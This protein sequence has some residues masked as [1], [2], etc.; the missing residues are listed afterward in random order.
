MSEYIEI[1]P[2]PGETPDHMI[3]ETNLKLTAPGQ[4]PELYMSPAEMEEG[5]P[6]AQSL[7]YVAGLR[8][9][10]ISGNLITVV[11]DPQ[12]DWHIIIAD[13]SAAVRDFFL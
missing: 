7:A 3:L 6:L 12:V 13:I 4:A 8:E 1:E 10:R 9:C 11:R 5:S 2:Q